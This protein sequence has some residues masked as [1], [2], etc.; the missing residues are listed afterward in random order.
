MSDDRYELLDLLGEGGM[1]TVHRARQ[2]LHGFERIVAL[3]R[4]RPELVHQPEYVHRFAREARIVSSLSHPNIAQIHD[5]DGDF[6]AMEYVDGRS[7][8]DISRA[9]AITELEIPLPVVLWLARTLADVLDHVHARGVIHRDVSLGNVLV[10]RDGHVKVIDFGVSTSPQFPAS[11][12]TIAGKLGYMAPETLRGL[13]GDQRVDVWGLGV[14]MWELLAGQP[15]FAGGSDK[16]TIS[17]V[18]HA[19]HAQVADWRDCP[20]ALDELLAA[21]LA[22]DPERRPASAASV[23]ARLDAIVR[24]ERAEIHPSAV[25]RWL[26][27]PRF[28]SLWSP[29]QP[30]S[31]SVDISV[32]APAP[33]ARKRARVGVA[34]LVA[35]AAGGTLALVQ[36][37][38]RENVPA[39]AHVTMQAVAPPAHTVLPPRVVGRSHAGRSRQ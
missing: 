1:A 33:V 34:A 31:H 12:R 22:K 36:A 8:L 35:L 29:P 3:K 25:A 32:E 18:L 20:R 19:R 23:R 17:A 38:P 30:Q 7:L 4:M 9:A 27:N 16:A 5:F 13:D 14:V 2:Q 37:S 21:M 15:L 6:I 26:A 24:A 10:T 11:A 39:P 28:A